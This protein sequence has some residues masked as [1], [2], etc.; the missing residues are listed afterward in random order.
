MNCTVAS[1]QAR[2]LLRMDL[3]SME[4]AAGSAS[5]GADGVVILPF[6]NG[7]RTPN[8]PKGKG[9]ILGLDGDNMTSAN[10]VRASMEAAVFGLRAGLEAFARGH[11][12]LAE[13]FDEIRLHRGR[14]GQRR[15]APDRGGQ[16][17]SAGSP[18][19]LP[20][21]CRHGRRA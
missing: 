17:R 18:A 21:R 1:E 6:Y 9:C 16:F 4:S 2:S 11:D 20:G 5:P 19:G 12:T 7:E 8:L 14:S 3:E 13:D 15:V 10:I